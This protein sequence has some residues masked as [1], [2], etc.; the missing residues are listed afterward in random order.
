MR[1]ARL[2]WNSS[3]TPN[4]H[5]TE[6]N[7]NLASMTTPQ[8]LWGLDSFLHTPIQLMLFQVKALAP[9]LDVDG[10]TSSIVTPSLKRNIMLQSSRNCFVFYNPTAIGVYTHRGH[11]VR[12]VEVLGVVRR[13]HRAP[14]MF[15]YT[16][17]LSFLFF[18]FFFLPPFTPPSIIF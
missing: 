12:I 7:V 18:F 4:S 13:V 16:C 17:M 15:V 8:V 14:K 10:N 5:S 3:P 1:R 9:V 11:P 2:L 6:A